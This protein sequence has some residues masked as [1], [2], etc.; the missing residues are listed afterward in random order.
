MR[1]ATLV[2][3][4]ELEQDYFGLNDSSV[5]SNSVVVIP[6]PLAGSITPSATL[7][8]QVISNE[9]ITGGAITPTGELAEVLIGLND[10]GLE[11]FVTP[12]GTLIN[13]VSLATV[14]PEGFI[15][16]YGNLNL[17]INILTNGGITPEGDIFVPQEFHA[18]AGGITP[19]GD[20]IT[21]FYERFGSGSGGSIKKKKKS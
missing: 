17:Q 11:G 5:W 1:L 16:P 4:I 18:I 8:N 7:V 13:T 3:T 10:G 9:V 14:F 15:Y 21:T 2:P 20:I 12:T 19:T 6:L